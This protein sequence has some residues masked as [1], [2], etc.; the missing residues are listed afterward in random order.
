[1]AIIKNINSSSVVFS[2]IVAMSYPTDT[3]SETAYNPYVYPGNYD[4]HTG[5][6]SRTLLINVSMNSRPS[7]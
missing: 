3:E 4:M 1:M 5:D 2:S 7:W 6:P